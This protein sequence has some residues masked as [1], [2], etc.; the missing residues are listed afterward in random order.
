MAYGLPWQGSKNSVARWVVDVL[1]AAPV[2]VDLFAGGCAVTHAALESG[3]W[4]RVIANDLTDGPEVF[5]KAVAGEYRDAAPVAT[6]ADFEASGDTLTRILYSFKNDRRTYVYGRGCEALKIQASRMLAAPTLKARRLEY[7]RFIKALTQDM[8]RGRI[9]E[10]QALEALE[11][12]QRLEGLD[13]LPALERLERVQALEDLQGRLEVMRGDYEAVQV[14]DGATV[15][16]DPPY[17]N[18]AGY[19]EPFDFERFDAWLASVPYPVYVSEFIA[20]PG[21]VEV[22]SRER[23]AHTSAKFTTRATERIF[24][25]ARFA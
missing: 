23:S 22:A 10:L 2:L 8:P 18:T 24:V 14:P 16:A 7:M 11:R 12:V 6:R 17:R 20:P 9:H 5:A 13:R 21:C 19:G 4:G 15:Y 25:Q 1:P 3:K